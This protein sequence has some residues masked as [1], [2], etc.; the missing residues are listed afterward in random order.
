MSNGARH[1][2]GAVV[3]LIATP[4]LAGTLTLGLDRAVRSTRAF[5]LT[6]AE[7]YLGAALLVV[8]AALVGLLAGSRLS[9][10][11]SLVPG[12]AFALHGL[13][14]VLAPR[15]M[16]DISDSLVPEFLA[17]GY[18]FMEPLGV[19]LLLGVALVVASLPPS[20][21]RGRQAVP[22]SPHAAVPPHAAVF[23]Q[24]PVPPHAAE[25]GR[26]DRPASPAAP[27]G[28]PPAGPPQFGRGQDEPP[29]PPRRAA[30][31]DDDDDEGPGEWTRMYGGR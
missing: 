26:P 22:P 27:F 18:R 23:P 19:G 24:D 30:H 16:F 11:A 15:T 4:V 31:R 17:R 29:Y 20:R 2:L 28:P 8:A 5:E 12:L 14:W 21:W 1:G 6:G 10:L 25:P 3:G 7:R 13:G 9:P